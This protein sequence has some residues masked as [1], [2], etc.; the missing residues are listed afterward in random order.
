MTSC[1]AIC[2]FNE[3]IEANFQNLLQ[4]MAH[5]T[6]DT[7]HFTNMFATAPG[8][9]QGRGPY[10]SRHTCC[11]LRD[12]LHQAV[13]PPNPFDIDGVGWPEL[14]DIL[15]SLVLSSPAE[16]LKLDLQQMGSVG[17]QNAAQEISKLEHQILSYDTRC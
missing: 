3:I 7:A 11:P 15:V 14:L 9:L 8:M 6:K 16:Y 12:F 2:V 13:E 5:H 17:N 10:V 4:C 1:N